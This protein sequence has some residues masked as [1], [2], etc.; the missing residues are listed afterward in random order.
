MMGTPS[1]AKKPGEMVRNW[2]R[3]SSSPGRGRGR[4]Q[5]TQSRAKASGIAPGTTMPS[6]PGLFHT[7]QRLK[8][9]AYDSL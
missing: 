6:K 9:G 4:P 2:A 7:G 5:K 3:G 8:C 1:A